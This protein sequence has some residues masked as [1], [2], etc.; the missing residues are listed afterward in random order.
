MYSTVHL[1]PTDKSTCCCAWR[2][3]AEM[4]IHHG[5]LLCQGEGHFWFFP[6][7][8]GI[9]GQSEREMNLL[10]QIETAQL[11][12]IL[13]LVWVNELIDFW[14]EPFYSRLSELS[15]NTEATCVNNIFYLLREN[16]FFIYSIGNCVRVCGYIQYVR[17]LFSQLDKHNSMTKQRQESDGVKA[18]FRQLTRPRNASQQNVTN[19][20]F[21]RLCP[22]S[23]LTLPWTYSEL[24][25]LSFNLPTMLPLFTMWH[26]G[27]YR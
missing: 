5:T 26:P 12:Y 2:M 9:S 16:G 21:P 15:G 11:L 4:K 27:G 13:K 19:P 6:A 10:F 8:W 17:E 24:C 20:R 18:N 22:F 23:A 3:A 7:R 25:S 14:R 1:Q